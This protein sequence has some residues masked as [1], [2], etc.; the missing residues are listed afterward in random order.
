MTKSTDEDAKAGLVHQAPEGGLWVVVGREGR[1]G[2]DSGGVEECESRILF[3]AAGS[4]W[5]A[6]TPKDEFPSPKVPGSSAGFLSN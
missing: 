4:R 2:V 3:C 5:Q 1:A 6:D